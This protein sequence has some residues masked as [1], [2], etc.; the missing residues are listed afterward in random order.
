MRRALSQAKLRPPRRAII[1]GL[2]GNTHACEDA[3]RSYERD[4]IFS[5]DTLAALTAAMPPTPVSIN[6]LSMAGR[7]ASA[8]QSLL[9]ARFI[10]AELI[11][12]RAA[13]L[14]QFQ[15]MPDELANAAGVQELAKKYHER[16][17]SYLRTPYLR[18]AED[19]QA[20]ASVMQSAL[21]EQLGETRKAFG[22]SLAALAAAHEGQ[23]VPREQQAALYLL[24]V[25]VLWLY[26]LCRA[27]SR[28]SRPEPKPKPRSRSRA[29]TQTPESRPEPRPWPNPNPHPTQ[30]VIDRHIDRIF[31]SRVG[32]RFLVKHYVASREP[33]G[34]CMRTTAC[35]PLHVHCM[36][37]ACS[38]HAHCMRT[39]C[40]LH[41]HC[42]FRTL[43]AHTTMHV[44]PRWTVSWGSFRRSAAPQSY[45]R[46]PPPRSPPS[47]ACDLAR[48]RRSRCTLV[49]ARRRPRHTTPRLSP[50]NPMR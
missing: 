30:A 26:S 8:D 24:W 14:Q 22:V 50:C 29:Q 23:R 49:T 19:E 18:T 4:G 11:A 5:P 41:V 28:R 2:S 42:V 1:R 31:L 17:G 37:T 48:R 35:T 38:V 47:A 12:R 33:V 36:R 34:G 16:L 15:Q 44:H 25:H 39:A 6:Q 27:S 43:H 46:P 40:A 20:F 7:R 45:A 32:I 10:H 3:L 9:N 13:M 21:P